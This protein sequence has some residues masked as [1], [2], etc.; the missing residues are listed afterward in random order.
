[1]PE[2]HEASRALCVQAVTAAVAAESDRECSVV[3]VGLLA[4]EEATAERIHSLH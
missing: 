1:M 2:E 3:L 4:P